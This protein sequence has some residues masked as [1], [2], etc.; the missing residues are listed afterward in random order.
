MDK[1]LT[2]DALSETGEGQVMDYKAAIADLFT[3]MEIID[4]RIKQN[5]SE[6]EQLRSETRV[7]L[8]QMKAA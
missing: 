5:Q 6:T 8:A 3:Q 4:E 2:T 7:M 1:T